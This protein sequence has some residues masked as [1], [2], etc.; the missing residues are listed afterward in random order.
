[1]NKV[2]KIVSNQKDNI[3]EVRWMVNNVCNYNCRY[4]WPGSHDGSFKSPENI[5]QIIDNFDHMFTYYKTHLNKTRFHLKV[6]GGEP[7]LWKDLG[8][9]IEQLKKRH[10]IYFTVISNGSRTL[11]W[12]KEYGH[13]IDNAT[14]SYHVA[15]ANP[16][17]MIA[18]ADT[19]YELGKK[20]SVKVLMDPNLWDESVRVLE[21]MK[22]SKHSWFLTATEVIEPEHVASN[23]IEIVDENKKRYTPEQRSYFKNALK[24]MPG[25]SWIF[26]NIK[27]LIG[28]EIKLFESTAYLDNGTTIKARPETYILNGWNN[29]KGWS[30]N[31]G[32]ESVYIHWDGEVVGSCQETL[33]GLDYRYNILDSNF[34]QNFHPDLKPIVCNQNNCFC[35]TETHIS[36]FDLSK[37]DISGTGTEV[38]ITDDRVIRHH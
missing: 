21:Y 31:I 13:L 5:D 6:G 16:D 10:N 25:W 3:L 30:C 23:V 32:L 14:L 17:H 18:V 38:S 35:G 36:K 9:F 15:E 37:R 33:Y 28:G 20:T 34:V 22:T 7:T 2:I 8:Y 19:L 1:M 11:R 29:F 4:C 26:K 24:R 12:W 27:L